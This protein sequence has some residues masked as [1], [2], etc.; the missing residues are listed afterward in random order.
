[1]SSTKT[2]TSNWFQ[3]EIENDEITGGPSAIFLIVMFQMLNMKFQI[4]LVI[5]KNLV[6]Q[7]MGLA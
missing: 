7:T 3:Q 6:I 2:S 4:S 5:L 1:M